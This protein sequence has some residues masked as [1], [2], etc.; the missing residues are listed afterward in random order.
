M[1]SLRN[2]QQKLPIQIND[3]DTN[4]QNIHLTSNFNCFPR[5]AMGSVL[6]LRLDP[7]AKPKL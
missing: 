1:D 5:T 7:Q 2:R 3:I 4:N 6:R